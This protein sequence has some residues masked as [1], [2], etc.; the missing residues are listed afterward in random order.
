MGV[1]RLTQPR[2]RVRR[3]CS[4]QANS[5]T[6]PISRPSLTDY[7]PAV[8]VHYLIIEERDAH[9]LVINAHRLDIDTTVSSNEAQVFGLY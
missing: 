5:P 3:A 6:G 2:R 1:A 8:E 7:G 9:G 4:Y